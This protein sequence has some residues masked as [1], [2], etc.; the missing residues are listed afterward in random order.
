MKKLNYWFK[1]WQLTGYPMVP[2]WY[3]NLS[4]L[5]SKKEQNLQA[6]IARTHKQIGETLITTTDDVE[7]GDET[8]S[9]DDYNGLIHVREGLDS[10][11]SKVYI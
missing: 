1:V 2:K 11:I 6:G 10:A 3:K 7:W 5:W 8:D 9:A 4:I